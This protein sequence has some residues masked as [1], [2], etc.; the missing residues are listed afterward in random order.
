[1]KKNLLTQLKTKCEALNIAIKRFHSKFSILKKKGLPEL[2]TS[3]DQLVKLDDY[4]ERLYTIAADNNQF[5]GIKRQIIGKEFLEA[6]SLDLTI[7]YEVGH[8]FPTKPNFERYTE[9]DEIFRRMENLEIPSEK[10]WEQLC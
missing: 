6:L 3:N 1:M 10:R 4:Y 2:L 9:V 7:K 8:L 5:A